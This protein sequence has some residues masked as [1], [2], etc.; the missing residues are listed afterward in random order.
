MRQSPRAFRLCAVALVGLLLIPAPVAARSRPGPASTALALQQEIWSYSSN[1]S[2]P[3]GC[4]NED[5][6]HYRAWSGG[7]GGAFTATEQLCDA[8]ADGWNPGGIGVEAD[9]WVI[10]TLNG[11]SITGPSGETQQAVLMSQTKLKGGAVKSYYAVCVM[12]PFFLS[13]NT[14]TNPLPG[15]TWTFNLSAQATSVTYEVQAFMG[16]PDQQQLYC[17]PGEQNLLP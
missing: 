7:L 13:T 5:D 16:Y 2:A 12:P 9:V 11:L 17:P 4:L 1:P 10:G 6:Y 3:S 14:G 8:T 15:G